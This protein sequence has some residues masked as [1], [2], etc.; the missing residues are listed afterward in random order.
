MNEQQ[1][2]TTRTQAHV[3][4]RAYTPV[5]NMITAPPYELSPAAVLPEQFYDAARAGRHE[6]GAVALIRAML[7]DALACY[8]NLG[9]A[10]GRRNQRI[11]NEAEAWLFSDEDHW[12]FA[13]VNVCAALGIEPGYVR[14]GL[15]RWRRA[16]LTQSRPQRRLTKTV[17]HDLPIAA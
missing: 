12:P 5:L 16:S 17:R 13:F 10:K 1:Q 15:K 7:D 2:R 6:S 8:Q 14:R 9:S 11:A 4:A 3:P